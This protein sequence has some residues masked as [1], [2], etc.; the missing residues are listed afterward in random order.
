MS[1]CSICPRRQ[2]DR[3]LNLGNAQPVTLFEC[4]QNGADPLLLWKSATAKVRVNVVVLGS[5]HE[6]ADGTLDAAP[7]PSDLLVIGNHRARRLKMNDEADIRLVVSH[8]ER[9]R[10]NEGLDLVVQQQVFEMP[11]ICVRHRRNRR[12]A[13]RCGRPWRRYRVRRASS[14]RARRRAGSACRRCRSPA[15]RRCDG[16]ATTAAPS[17][18]AG[19]LPAGRVSRA[20]AFPAARGY[21]RTAPSRRRRHDRSRLRWCPVPAH[22]R[23]IRRSTLTRR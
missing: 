5:R 7:G 17:A 14:P 18:T 22:C 11:A 20:S 3:A 13:R 15:A 1:A 21:C 12:R 8:A 10:S 4:L 19:A 23:G 9:R 2:I 6:N 16:R